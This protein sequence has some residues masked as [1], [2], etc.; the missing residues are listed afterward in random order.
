MDRNYVEDSFP[1]I[2]KIMNK[3]LREGVVKT[4]QLAVAK[5]GW[6][7]IDDVP[8]TLLTDVKTSL[9]EHTRRVTDMAMAIGQ[10]RQDLNMDVLITGALVH[11]VG[12]LIEYTRKGKTIVKSEFGKMVRHPVSGYG[13]VLEAGLPVEIAHIVAAHSKEGESVTRSP[14]A[15]VIHHCDFIDFDIARTD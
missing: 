2:N 15:I 13:L 5:G 10:T 14:E 12:K 1:Q 7:K 8:F 4:W 3:D 6:D 11:D 9:I